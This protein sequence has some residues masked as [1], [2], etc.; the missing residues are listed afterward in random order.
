M[1]KRQ[2]YA[3][4]YYPPSSIT[5]DGYS[6]SSGLYSSALLGA[7][8]GIVRVGHRLA[9]LELEPTETDG[10][11]RRWMHVVDLADPA[12]PAHGEPLD[13]GESLGAMPLHV[14]NG[15]V[16]TSRW[17]VSPVDAAKVR[18]YA[19]RVDLAGPEP[20]VLSAISTP[21]SLLHVDGAS[22]RIV[23]SDYTTK[24]ADA[25]NSHQC[26]EALG[27]RAVFDWQTNRCVLVDRNLKLSDVAG[28]TVKVRH[29]LELPER[30]LSGVEVAEDRIYLTSGATLYGPYPLEASH[31]GALLAIG[32]IRAGALSIVS[33]LAGDARWP[34][35]SSGTKVALYTARGI[36]V[37]DTSTPVATLVASA[38]LRGAGYS[39]DVIMS[40][41]TAFAALG[42]FGL[43]TLRY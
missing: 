43:Q 3:Y 2:A 25:L 20:K 28:A 22:S 42:E 13:L 35:A 34:L 12:A 36:D 40:S 18:F 19:D 6:Y 5:Y 21:G 31:P 10:R 8:E 9:F 17:M 32:G 26:Y 7:G 1:Y 15:V 41:T 37:Y 23:T 38:Q 11:V 29:V 27:G 30:Y 33:E 24:Q 16:M 4:S 39:S 14:M